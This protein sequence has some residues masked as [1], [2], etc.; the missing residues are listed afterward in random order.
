MTSGMRSP[1]QI[2]Y[3]RSIFHDD[4]VFDDVTGWR[5]SWPLYSCLGEV[6]SWNK[7]QGQYLVN[8]CEHRD[9]LCRLHMP[10]EDLNK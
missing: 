2:I 9:R 4:D 1:S 3:T 5:G 10:K 6:G 8:R 7:L